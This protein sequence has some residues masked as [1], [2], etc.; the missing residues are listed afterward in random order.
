M[1]LE[2][3]GH[4]E[5]C[6]CHISGALSSSAST[7]CLWHHVWLPWCRRCVNSGME[8]L[9]LERW[10][11]E[12]WDKSPFTSTSL[13]TKR[14][15]RKGRDYNNWSFGY[16]ALYASRGI[17]ESLPFACLLNYILVTYLVGLLKINSM[18]FLGEERKDK[19]T[20]YG[21]RQRSTEYHI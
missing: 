6:L 3:L 21:W 18:F 9:S 14:W 8:K 15:S 2:S 5:S 11:F 16:N 17:R 13:V 10:D 1:T 12:K 20:K 7:V 4:R 19:K